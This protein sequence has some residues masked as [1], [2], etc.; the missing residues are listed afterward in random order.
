MGLARRGAFYSADPW[1]N[2]TDCIEDQARRACGRARLASGSKTA[3]RSFAT[4]GS[5]ACG[6]VTNITGFLASTSHGLLASATGGAALVG[7]N[8]YAS[9]PYAPAGSAP[10]RARSA[11]SWY[12]SAT[13]RRIPWQ[14]PSGFESDA[15][16]RRF[17][18]WRDSS[19]T[20]AK[21][22]VIGVVSRA[23]PPPTSH[24]PS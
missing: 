6:N 17:A 10:N 7:S 18:I 8:G 1:V 11:A 13:S 20:G 2:A 19:A 15:S 14:S 23:S 22:A 16:P 9:T 5:I 12:N 21:R 24:A 3:L 4:A